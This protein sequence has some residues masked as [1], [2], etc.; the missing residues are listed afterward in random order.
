MITLNGCFFLS[1][2]KLYDFGP[3]RVFMRITANA[4]CE[5][6]GRFPHGDTTS[7]RKSQRINQQ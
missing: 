6:S 3:E 7:I 5:C 4:Y 2:D 1:L